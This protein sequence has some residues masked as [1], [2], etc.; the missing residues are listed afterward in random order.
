[1]MKIV[2]RNL[3]SSKRVDEYRINGLV[4]VGNKEKVLLF[5]ETEDL[6]FA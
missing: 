4:E 6:L 3:Y 2:N 5:Y 1:M